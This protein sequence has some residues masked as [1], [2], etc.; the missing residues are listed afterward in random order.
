MNNKLSIIEMM[1]IIRPME[2]AIIDECGLHMRNEVSATF[3]QRKFHKCNVM[4]FNYWTD[5][6]IE[7]LTMKKSNFLEKYATQAD[8]AQVVAKFDAEI[9]RLLGSKNQPFEK[10]VALRPDY[11]DWRCYMHMAQD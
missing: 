2:K 5:I 4:E 10:Y 6:E 7:K 9:V 8:S 11:R 3:L 1:D